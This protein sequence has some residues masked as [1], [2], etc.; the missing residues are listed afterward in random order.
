MSQKL[1]VIEDPE[2]LPG[3]Q[4]TELLSTS[5]EEEEILKTNLTESQTDSK[6]REVNEKKEWKN[7]PFKACLQVYCTKN[8]VNWVITNI[9]R[10]QIYYKRTGGMDN[11]KGYLK[12]SQKLAI[13]NAELI[14]Q[15][16][17]SLK[18]DQLFCYLRMGYGTKK[19]RPTFRAAAKIVENFKSNSFKTYGGLIDSTRKSISTVRLK[20]GRRGRR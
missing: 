9:T 1:K 8:N 7:T 20:G 3:K 19:H 11:K 15:A 6:E 13:K 14:V 12:N 10:D 16:L 18:V 2:E 4:K 5:I 17:E